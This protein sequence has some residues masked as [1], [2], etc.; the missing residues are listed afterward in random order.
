MDLKAYYQK[1]REV[2]RSLTDAYPVVVSQ[3]TP[4][5]GIAGVKTEAPAHLAAKMIAEGLARAAS[6]EETKEFRRQ[7]ADAKRAADHAEASKSIPVTVVSDRDLKSLR[8]R[9]T[10]KA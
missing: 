4:D 3:G 8:S 1:I 2:E 6:E 5:G 10:P 9:K 7:K